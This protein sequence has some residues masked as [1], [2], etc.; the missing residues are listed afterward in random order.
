M[1]LHPMSEVVGH[2]NPQSTAIYARLSIDPIK[3]SVEKVT[4]AMFKH[5]K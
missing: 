3:E 4:E 2:K 1:A 5:V